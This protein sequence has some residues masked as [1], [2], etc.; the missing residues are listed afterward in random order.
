MIELATRACAVVLILC[1]LALEASAEGCDEACLRGHMDRYL[2]ALVKHDPTSL[3]VP[4]QVRVTENG[5]KSS[6]SAGLWRTAKSIGT[7]RSIIVDTESEQVMFIGTLAEEAG[8]AIA[9]L[10]IAVSDDIILE[11]EHVVARQGSHPLFA[12]QSVVEHPS[13]KA[14]VAPESRASRAELIAVAD[15]Y[16]EGIERHSSENIRATASCQRVENGVPTTGGERPSK[17]CADSAERLT[18]IKAVRNRRFPVVDVERGIVVAT[19]LFDVPGESSPANTAR[20][21]D[22]QVAARLRQPRTLLLTEWFKIN[23]G[24]IQHIEAVMHNL[25]HG[26]SSGWAQ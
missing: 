13:L 25:P 18:Y 23:A 5:A 16:F 24:E 9:A 8:P 14:P 1:S 6:L 11:I 7:A 3:K 10:R 17:S 4:E 26:A 2:A 20:G 15:T 12:P 22:P 19:V 21:E